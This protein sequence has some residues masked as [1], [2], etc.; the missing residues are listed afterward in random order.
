MPNPSPERTLTYARDVT[1][2][3][4]RALDTF[5]YRQLERVSDQVGE[6]GETAFAMRALISLVS[7]S[8]A[9]LDALV[10]VE[11]PEAWQQRMIVTEWQ[12]LR[13]TAK[14][15]NHCDGYDQDRW[16]NEI[17]HYDAAEEAAEQARIRRITDA[18]EDD[19]VSP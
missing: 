1:R 6:T 18:V 10:Q 7:N 8:A 12:R 17:R 9:F 11:Q 2:E 3:D 19:T 15:F 4:V 5:L 14:D 16:W 13:G